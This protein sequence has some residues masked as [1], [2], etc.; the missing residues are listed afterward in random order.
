VAPPEALGLMGVARFALMMVL[1]IVLPLCVQLWDRRRQ[2][3]EQRARGWNT[4]TWGSSLYAFGPLSMLGWIFVTR[5]R[6]V[7]CVI[8]PL[9][10]LPQLGVLM[11]VDAAFGYWMMRESVDTSLG[12]IGAT[13]ALGY[14]GMS[15]VLGVIELVILA[16]RRWRRQSTRGPEAISV[17]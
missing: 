5:K 12:E 16:R 8:A 17:N 9:W 7:R 11:L 4:A 1:G 10:T 13:A 6:L 14:V 15:A 2:S 3:A